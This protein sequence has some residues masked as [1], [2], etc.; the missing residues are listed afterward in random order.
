MGQPSY[1][2]IRLFYTVFRS[3]YRGAEPAQSSCCKTGWVGNGDQ[4]GEDGST[5]S[6]WVGETGWACDAVALS[7]SGQSGETGGEGLA[8]EG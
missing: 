3:Q 4:L 5:D 2:M 1:K 7:E 8:M 6:D